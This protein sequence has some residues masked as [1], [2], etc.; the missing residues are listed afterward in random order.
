MKA[1]I[2]T[3][4]KFPNGDA[5]S[6]RDFMFARMLKEKQFDVL[7]IG[8]G[9]SMGKEKKF[10]EGIE[11]TSLRTKSKN[12]YSKLMSFIQYGWTLINYLGKYSQKE[13]IDILWIVGLPIHAA[14]MLKS[15]AKRSKIILV[16]D[17]VEWYS[18]NQFSLGV[19]SPSFISKEI[20]NRFIIDKSFIVIAI[21]KYLEKYYSDRSIR[22]IRIPVV[23]DMR[24]V[25]LSIPKVDTSTKIKIMYAGSPGKKD[26]LGYILE[27]VCLLTDE[28]LEKL[29]F[30]IMGIEESRIN[31]LFR[32]RISDLSRIKKSLF[33]LGKVPR[34]V[35]LDNLK[36]S[37]FS[38]LLRSSKQ[39]YA[40]AGFPTK[41]VESLLVGT[42]IIL[43][44]TSDL[45]DYITDGENGIVVEDCS[46]KQFYLALQRAM[47]TD[48]TTRQKMRI[49]ARKS[50]EANFDYRLYIETLE[51]I[52][53]II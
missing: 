37:D 8:M 46:P 40:K 39:R 6:T 30:T 49:M 52:T 13:K 44:L 20:N 5:G 23:M 1:V 21:S 2:V 17:S 29:E 34:E 53:S 33:I 50:F 25:T 12:T 35:V 16:H 3:Y 9:I 11:Y 22:T 41:V 51:S 48:F 45:S 14:L 19:L 4:N 15:F 47:I 28:Q 7:V 18:P 43:N 10:Y 27:G 31:E 38:V 26:F 24:E 42:P 36:L 32:N